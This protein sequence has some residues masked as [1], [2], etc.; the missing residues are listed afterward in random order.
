MGREKLM[1]QAETLRG[2]AEHFRVLASK[3]TDTRALNAIRLLIEELEGRARALQ[4][5]AGDG[6]SP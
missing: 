1:A 3:L 2:E 6:H 4:I 5:Q